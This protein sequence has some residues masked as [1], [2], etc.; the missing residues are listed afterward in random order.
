MTI[1]FEITNEVSILWKRTSH[2]NLEYYEDK[3]LLTS[4]RLKKQFNFLNTIKEV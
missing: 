1:F 4:R 3:K 2:R